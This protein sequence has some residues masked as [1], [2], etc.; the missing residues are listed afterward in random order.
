MYDGFGLARDV[1]EG[2]DEESC[3]K[4]ANMKG[5]KCLR[6]GEEGRSWEGFGEGRE[7]GEERKLYEGGYC[8]RRNA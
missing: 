4:G 7:V 1:F 8:E 3:T 6:L 5:K 2:L